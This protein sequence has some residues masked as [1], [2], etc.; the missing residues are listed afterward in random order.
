MMVF[1]TERLVVRHLRGE[2]LD[3][4]AALC[5]DPVAMRYMGDGRP[6][7]REQ[8]ATWIDVSETNYRTRGYGCFAVTI[9]PEDRLIGFCGLVG[10]PR[11]ELIELIYA[12]AQPYWAR[13]LA[14]EVARAAIAYGFER[15]R[16]DR[17]EATIYP[18]IHSSKRVLEKIGRST[19][20]ASQTSM[21]STST[22][23]R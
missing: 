22:S 19:N 9:K 12:F 4:F 21:D 15:H 10:P 23:T 6:L 2:D 11:Q 20:D 8:T 18:A 7:T 3:E 14:T 13:G 1:E 17:I 16:L 5:G